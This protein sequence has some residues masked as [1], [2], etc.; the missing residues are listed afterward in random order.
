M[1][2]TGEARRE[3]ADKRSALLKSARSLCDAFASGSPLDDVLENFSTIDS[4]SS[5]VCL[6]HGLS[7]LAPFLGREFRGLEGAREYFGIISDLLTYENMRFSGYAVDEEASLVS[8]VGRA[9]FTWKS[10]GDSWDEVFTY[11]LKFD[12]YAKVEVYEVWADS[13]AAYLASKGGLG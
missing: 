6:E 5:V 10:T 12:E 9:T 13:G 8:V 7:N 1:A 11:R 3:E 2:S 4:G